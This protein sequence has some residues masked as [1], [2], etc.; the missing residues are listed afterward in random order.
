MGSEIET[1]RLHLRPLELSEAEALH[2]LWTDPG[3]RRYLFD[4]EIIPLPQV[5]REIRE[6]LDL[7]VAKGYGLWGVRRLGRR[8]LE[9]FCGFRF[10]HAP[11]ELQL[12]FGLDPAAWNKGLTTE[13]AQAMLR[14]GF[15]TCE[16][17]S[18]VASADAPNAASLRVMEKA[19]ML[20]DRRCFVHGRDTVYYSLE[21]AAFRPHPGPYQ[22][23]DPQVDGG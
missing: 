9:G 3:I 5:E 16:M 18:I 15:E 8:K 19:G 2:G 12:L 17:E 21:R 10:F 4:N 22:I 6:S 1:A 13:M 11:P 7:H 14:Y 20:F 23:L